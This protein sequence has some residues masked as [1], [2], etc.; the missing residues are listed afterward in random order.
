MVE[1]VV[2]GPEWGHW[3]SYGHCLGENLRTLRVMRGLSQDRLAELSGLSRNQIS[4]IERNE[5]TSTRSADPVLST[6]Y[7][8]ARALH[9]PPVALLPAADRLVEE[10]CPAEGVT[11]DVVWPS[12]PEDTMAFDAARLYGPAPGDGP[13]FNPA[14]AREIAVPPVDHRRGLPPGEESMPGSAAG[15][16]RRPPS[17]GVVDEGG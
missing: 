6:V 11:V 1:C 14:T 9:V 12:R 16:H 4:N 7:R 3:A 2:R 5:N 17:P 15:R 8:L 13:T 10:I